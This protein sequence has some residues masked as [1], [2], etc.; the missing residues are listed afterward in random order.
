MADQHEMLALALAAVAV[1]NFPCA[2]PAQIRERPPQLSQNA[3]ELRVIPE[4]LKHHGEQRDNISYFIVSGTIV[5]ESGGQR[6]IP[7]IRVELRDNSGKVLRVET[8]QTER[9][10][11]RPGDAASFHARF[12][13]PPMKIVFTTHVRLVATGAT[14]ERESPSSNSPPTGSSADWRTATM[15]DWRAWSASQRM[16]V[17]GAISRSQGGHVPPSFLRECIDHVARDQG[18]QSQRITEIAAMCVT[19]GR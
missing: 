12:A 10:F 5:N 4:S 6:H 11:L 7:E 14:L 2:S 13:N 17:T 9:T 1:V 16:S 15:R 18:V 3:G 19:M 8:A